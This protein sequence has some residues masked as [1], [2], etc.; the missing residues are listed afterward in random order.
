MTDINEECINEQW[1]SGE[2]GRDE[3]FIDVYDKPEEIDDLL[4]I[5]TVNLRLNKDTYEFIEKLAQQD[6]MIVKAKIRQILESMV[7]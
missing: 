5:K 7:K 6:G 4:G 2:Y 3:Q 1:E